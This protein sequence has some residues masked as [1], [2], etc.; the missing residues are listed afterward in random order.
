MSK[1]IRSAVRAI[2]REAGPMLLKDVT[3]RL[4]AQGAI[5]TKNPCETV[6]GAVANDRH[7]VHVGEHRYV[8]LPAAVRGA[9]VRVPMDLAS[10]ARKLLA[11]PT[12]A[13]ALL[14]TSIV[15]R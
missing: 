3:E 4:I 15:D 12:E 7:C 9:T 8:F 10:L 13:H 2:L 6:R 1:A 11:V 14:S 5:R